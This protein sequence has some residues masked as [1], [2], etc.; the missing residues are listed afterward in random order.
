MARTPTSYRIEYDLYVKGHTKGDTG[1]AHGR[2][3]TLLD[4]TRVVRNVVRPFDE[5]GTVTRTLGFVREPTTKE[6]R[7]AFVRPLPDDPR[8]QAY[9]P[10]TPARF[11]RT[12]AGRKCAS[13]L[14]DGAEYCVDRDGIV[15]LTRT[16]NSVEVVR[17]VKVG[18]ETLGA[19][20]VASALRK[21]FSE[22]D[23]G[24]I[25]PLDPDTAPTGAIDYSLA[26]EPD[27]FSL[28]GRYA[29]V[30]LTAEVLK[31][32]S[33]RVV[34]GIVDVYVRGGDAVIVERGGK[35][36]AT[37]VGDQDLGTLANGRDVELGDVLGSGRVG[38]GGSGA[39]GYREVRATP[40]EGRYVVVAGTLPEDALIDVA[41]SLQAWPGNGLRYL[42][43]S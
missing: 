24:S 37:A 27:G 19:D 35:L 15:L 33:Q 2:A 6:S 38:I 28:V 14:V 40:T 16:A 12:V 23:L 11:R 20:A 39:F 42:D 29:V 34:A 32:G 4:P 36:D 21:G 43:A 25:R 18:D 8:P 10:S 3:R 7:V 9:P 26:A 22:R 1:V 13:Y 30:P 17:K 41:R 5:T 31:R